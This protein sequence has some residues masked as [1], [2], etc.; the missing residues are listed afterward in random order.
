MASKKYN[1]K[2]SRLSS[3]KKKDENG[4]Y[5]ESKKVIWRTVGNVSVY[6]VSGIPEDLRIYVDIPSI[7]AD[8]V[9][10]PETDYKGPKFEKKQEKKDFSGFQ[11][12]D[13]GF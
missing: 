4:K 11:E 8:I 1:M 13:Y 12:D 7:P 2:Y 9:V 3:E 5:V 10:L 6:S